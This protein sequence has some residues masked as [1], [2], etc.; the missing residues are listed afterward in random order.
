MQDL[1]SHEMRN[2]LSAIMQCADGIT[3]L[4]EESTGS[5]S[6]LDL[7]IMANILESAQTVLLCAAHQKRYEDTNL[8]RA[9]RRH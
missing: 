5:P 7:K 9:N 2:P 3:T 8:K 1:T 6:T 4:V